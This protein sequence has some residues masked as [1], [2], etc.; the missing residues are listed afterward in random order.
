MRMSHKVKSVTAFPY[1]DGA[2]LLR[3]KQAFRSTQNTF[4]SRYGI[5]K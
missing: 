3:L 1:D 2:V 4:K 5:L